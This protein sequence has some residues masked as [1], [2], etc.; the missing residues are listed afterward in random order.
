MNTKLLLRLNCHVSEWWIRFINH[1]VVIYIISCLRHGKHERIIAQRSA[2]SLI[3]NVGSGKHCCT[4]TVSRMLFLLF[5]SSRSSHSTRE[6]FGAQSSII[7]CMQNLLAESFVCVCVCSFSFISLSRL[8]FGNRNQH[9]FVRLDMWNPL[10]STNKALTAYDWMQRAG[11]RARSRNTRK[12]PQSLKPFSTHW[13]MA[14]RLH[15]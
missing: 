12:K 11:A 14:T 9:Y 7:W 8:F 15:I 13:K 4:R 2:S 5:L 6:F 3:A 10:E 1:L